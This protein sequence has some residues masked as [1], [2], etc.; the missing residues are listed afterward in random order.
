MVDANEVAKHNTK[1][2]CWVILHGK[3][4][5]LTEFLPKHPGGQAIILKY[6]GQ[7]ASK[8]FDPIHPPDIV[9]KMLSKDKHLG[10]VE[11]LQDIA[12]TDEDEE[13][14]TEEEKQRLEL[15]KY[16]PPLSQM[17]N[18]F[19]FEYVASKTMGYAG[20]KYY[21]SASDD[22]ITVREN[23]LAFHR[24]W[25]RPRVMIDVTTVD[26]STTML[27]SPSS[28]PFYITATALGR[29]GHEDGEKVLTVSAGK[30][31]VIYMIPT[32]S[33]CSLDEILD[34]AIDKQTL[35]MQIYVNAE[36]E[37][38]EEM[39]KA[40]EARGVKA[41]WVTV[42]APQLGRREKDMRAKYIDDVSNLQEEDDSVDRSQGAARAISS[43]IDVSL[44]WK[45][46][47]WFRSITKKPLVL[48]GIQRYEDV[49]LAI[50]HGVDGVVLS[51]HGGRQLE[52]SRPSIEVLAETMAVLRQKG[53]QDK[54]E[55]YID[56][57]I[58]R[59]T[60]VLKAICLGAK[61]VGIGRPFLY[62]MST[63]GYDG[64]RQA[65]RLLKDELEMNMR[66]LGVNRLD[67][68]DQSFLDIRSLTSHSGAPA[69]SL[70]AKV[71]EP[72]DLP[73]F[74]SNL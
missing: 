71:Y 40:A 48:K 73:K 41:F 18:L 35:W 24:I 56:G 25:F 51:N 52:Y 21:S 14:V 13:D 62:A 20:W 42:D 74:K 16:K 28:T 38:T 67:E 5:D 68:L 6:A 30:E 72:L 1:D 37:M 65:I 50:E 61:G 39:V 3:A 23:H 19:D 4:Y 47:K 33:S 59:G 46:I 7:D 15:T 43:F 63:Y 32:L 26:F 53:L 22:E 44:S 69:D 66:L 36:R 60:D 31:N 45:D 27:G 57:G 2:D 58:R 8:A 12:P 55:I 70:L 17:F 34:V 9:N 10:D 49:L 64:V 11:N 54:I 29:L